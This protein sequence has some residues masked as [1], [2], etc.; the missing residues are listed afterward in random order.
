MEWVVIAGVVVLAI[1]LVVRY[2]LLKNAL[3]DAI[4]QLAH[5][6][7]DVMQN[8]RMHL[9][10]PNKDL[11]ALVCGINQMVQRFQEERIQSDCRERAFQEQIEAISHDLRTPLTVIVGYLSMMSEQNKCGKLDA[12][13]LAETLDV[14]RRKADGMERLVN[15]F[16]EYSRLIAN[17]TVLACEA[18]DMGKVVRETLLNNVFLLEQAGID[19]SVSIDETPQWVIA[20]AGALERVVTNLLQNV[21][22][23]AKSNLQVK[24]AEREETVQLQVVNDTEVLKENDLHHLF[25]RFYAGDKARP[26]GSSGLGLTI[27]RGLVEEMDGTMDAVMLPTEDDMTE[28]RWICFTVGLKKVGT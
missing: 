22:R 21:A 6:E 15:Q 11:E 27:A 24:V 1:F 3:Q 4:E 20:D 12:N 26:T 25:E 10:V 18:V 9:S 28:K 13:E 17:D 8:R 14:L 23:Y 7:E 2:V 5:I 19:V 16:Y